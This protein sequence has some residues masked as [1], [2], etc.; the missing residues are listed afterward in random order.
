M[1]KTMVG[2]F[3]LSLFPAMAVAGTVAANHSGSLAGG[4]GVAVSD[5]GHCVYASRVVPPGGVII[6]K[7]KQGK[8]EWKQVCVLTP[9]GWG[10]FS[11]PVRLHEKPSALSAKYTVSLGGKVVYSGKV[12]LTPA[13]AP[14]HFTVTVTKAGKVVGGGFS[15]VTLPGTPM[16]NGDV[17]Q[18]SYVSGA[19]SADNSR[20]VKLHTATL[21]Y[22][23]T[24]I[25]IADKNNVVQFIGDI[26]KLTSLKAHHAHGLVVQTPAF[27]ELQANQ[28]VVL[29]PGQSTMFSMGKYQVKV[30]RS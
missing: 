5:K 6:Q 9:T 28:T 13:S 7:N 29:A 22:G 30:A 14:E 1:S 2:L 15:G 26:T 3:A 25:L 16:S 17:T 18:I 20:T 19:S 21:T 10:K 4:V 23:K 24:F 27:Q 11:K 8:P 12:H